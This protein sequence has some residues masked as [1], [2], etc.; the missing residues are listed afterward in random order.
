VVE[1]KSAAAEQGEQRNRERQERRPLVYL[2]S[3]GNNGMELLASLGLQDEA[4]LLQGKLEEAREAKRREKLLSILSEVDTDDGK[5][6]KSDV[7][8]DRGDGHV[9]G[10]PGGEGRSRAS[11]PT[12]NRERSENMSS[13]DMLQEVLTYWSEENRLLVDEGEITTSLPT[14]PNRVKGLFYKAEDLYDPDQDLIVQLMRRAVDHDV[15]WCREGSM[16]IDNTLDIDGEDKGEGEGEG[17]GETAGTTRA[18]PSGEESSGGM[19]DQIRGMEWIPPRRG[20]PR[21]TPR[22]TPRHPHPD[23]HPYPHTH[24]YTREPLFILSHI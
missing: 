21:P 2:P 1:L 19:S 8:G 7:G 23:L 14:V 9:H 10:G 4:D 22:S 24:T 3:Y 5:G 12:K 15:Q 17:E 20:P 6:G 11:S 16:R 18:G 13:M